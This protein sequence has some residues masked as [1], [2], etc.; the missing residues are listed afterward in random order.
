MPW[1]DAF[2]GVFKPIYTYADYQQAVSTIPIEHFLYEEVDVAKSDLDKEAEAILETCSPQ[3]PLLAGAVIGADMMSA[4]FADYITKYA[5]NPH[6]KGTRQV[7]GTDQSA[8]LVMQ[9]QF[10]KNTQLLGK[11]NL[12]CDVHVDVKHIMNGVKLVQSAPDTQCVITH[13]GGISADCKDDQLWALW[14]KGNGGLC[15]MPEY[16]V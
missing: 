12:L 2:P 10:I 7:C 6:I 5:N 3:H 14:R 1:L 16:G 15:S 13:V 8:E 4:D 9:P 11:L